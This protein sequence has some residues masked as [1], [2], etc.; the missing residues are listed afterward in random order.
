MKDRQR[1]LNSIVNRNPQIKFDEGTKFCHFIISS[2]RNSVL[3]RPK[4]RNRLT[5]IGPLKGHSKGENSEQNLLHLLH[6]IYII[7]YNSGHVFVLAKVA[8]LNYIRDL[9]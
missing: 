7:S 9:K 6:H 8:A 2:P 4:P 1:V 3:F 5:V